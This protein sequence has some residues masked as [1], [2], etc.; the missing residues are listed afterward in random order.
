MSSRVYHYPYLHC[1]LSPV[2]AG[3][4][5]RTDREYGRE[6]VT[7]HHY[8]SRKVL[9]QAQEVRQLLKDLYNIT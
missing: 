9:P 7:K 8:I 1:I 3:T 6:P 4:G 5:S 2:R